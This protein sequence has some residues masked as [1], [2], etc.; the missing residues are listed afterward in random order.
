MT[1]P[2]YTATKPYK[3]AAAFVLTFLAALVALVQDKTEFGDL[4]GLQWLVAVASA[5]VTA[6]V[7]YGVPNP[8]K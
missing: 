3:A 6:G 5:L 7:V 2:A 4:S 1:T 8:P